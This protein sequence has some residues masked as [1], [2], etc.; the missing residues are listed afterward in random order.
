S[1]PGWFWHVAAAGRDTSTQRCDGS[2][3]RRKRSF[4]RGP[5]ARPRRV[6]YQGSMGP[7][8]IVKT[9]STMPHLSARRGDYE[10]WIADG[11]GV[12]AVDVRDVV[13]GDPLPDPRTVGAVMVTG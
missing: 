12:S 7:V 8:L 5:R 3:T 1:R 11:L 13:R 4:A 2:G 9:G 10:D 6:C